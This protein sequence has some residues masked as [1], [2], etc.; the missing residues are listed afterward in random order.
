MD[1]LRKAEQA[2]ASARFLIGANDPDGASNRAYYAMFDAA[3]CALTAL[4]HETGKT[5]KGVLAAFS[6]HC[7]KSG[8]LPMETGRYLKQAETRRYVADYGADNIQIAEAEVG[9]KQAEFVVQAVQTL[10]T[11]LNLKP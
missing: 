4:G 5:H 9:V 3:L 2:C 6:E 7:I 10:V 8:L 1:L 11:N